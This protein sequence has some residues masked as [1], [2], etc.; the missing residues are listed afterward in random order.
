MHLMIQT[1]GQGDSGGCAQGKKRGPGFLD[2][3]LPFLKFYVAVQ[4]GL[5]MLLPE[6]T[7]LSLKETVPEKHYINSGCYQVLEV[8][9][10]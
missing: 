6:T 8:L 9:V 10:K 4:T 5:R 1:L 3:L 2:S 7:L